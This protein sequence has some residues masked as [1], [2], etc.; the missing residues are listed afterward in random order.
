MAKFDPFNESTWKLNNAD[1]EEQLANKAVGAIGQ[2]I[3][4]I[5][6]LKASLEKKFDAEDQFEYW[7]AKNL[8]QRNPKVYK[9]MGIIVDVPDAD[10][11]KLLHS[12]DTVLDMWKDVS[13]RRSNWRQMI[14]YLKD[15]APLM[16]KNSLKY[17]EVKGLISAKIIG[18][19]IWEE[20]LNTY[21]G[22]NA[23][24]EAYKARLKGIKENPNNNSDCDACDACDY[25]YDDGCD[26]RCHD[27]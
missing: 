17:N 4:L 19:D 18:N 7:L 2:K 22:L 5:R 11:K 1:V 3:H 20:Y 8:E 21:K 15:I 6:E 25:C 24:I 14:P 27:E 13:N 26:C 10:I 23:T 9:L 16:D 12:I